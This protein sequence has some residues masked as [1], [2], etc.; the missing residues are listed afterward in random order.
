MEEE[1]DADREVVRHGL[2]TLLRGGDKKGIGLIAK[3]QK[4]RKLSLELKNSKLG[5]YMNI[6][7]DLS[8]IY[9]LR[10][11]KKIRNKFFTSPD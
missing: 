9:S 2:L 5:W 4:C 10:C 7:V 6:L 1:Q 8:T 3:V 11:Y